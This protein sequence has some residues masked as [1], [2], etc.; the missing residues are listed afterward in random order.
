MKHLRT[1]LAAIS[2]AAFLLL[3]APPLLL[4]VAV[5]L[6]LADLMSA[7]RRRRKR[8]AARDVSKQAVSVVIPT[9]N[10]REHLARN[11]PSVVRAL[12]A[13][14]ENEI[15]VMENGS[16]DGTAELL[17]ESFPSVR[18]V[19][20]GSNLGFGR[21]SNYG[22]TL[23]RHDIV[24]LLNNDMRVESDFLGPLVDGFRDPRVFAVTA[25]IHFSDPAKSR[26]E[27]GLTMGRWVRGGIHLRHVAD[28]Q[29]DE[30]FPT[31]YAGGGSTAYDRLKVLELG[32]YDEL[33]APF[34][35]EDVDLSYMAWKR[36]WINLY[37]PASMVHH[38]HRGTIGTHFS[39]EFIDQ[40]LQKNRLLFVWKNMHH[41]GL[42]LA[43]FGWLYADMWASLIAGPSTNRCGVRGFLRALGQSFGA[44][45]RRSSARLLAEI[46]DSEAFRRPLGGFFRDRYHR[47]ENKPD[48]DLNVL[49][50]SPYPIEPPT[51]G[52]AVFMKQATEGLAE[53]CRLHLLC[54][55]ERP[56][57]VARH[58]GLTSRC[59][60]AELVV[61]DPGLYRGAPIL[62]P[63]SAQSYWDPALLWK[64]HRTILLRRIDIVQLE[65]AQL[66]SYGERF[67]QVVCCLF[68]HDLHFQSVQRAILADGLGGILHRGYEYMRSLRFEL[69]ALPRFDAIQV[70]STEQRRALN[71]LCAGGP[72]VLDN[73]RTAIELSTYPCKI[74]DREPDTMLFVGNFRH[75][76]NIKGLQHF[77]Q[78]ILPLIRQ[79][80]PQSR[81]IVVGADAPE[82]LQAILAEDG[83]EFLGAVAD[84][85]AVLT[86]YAV[87]V[88]P[89]LSGSG[90]R[91]KIL[92]AF[93]CGI[94]VVSTR[95]GAE[96]LCDGA[97]GIA[98]I[99]DRPQ[100]FAAAVVKLL[101]D[102]GQSVA[103]VREAR[104]MVRRNWDAASALP[105]LL[106]HYSA[107][108]ETKLLSR[109]AY[110]PPLR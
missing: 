5:L 101:S 79:G 15:L 16:E 91:V 110:P 24:V 10:G 2:V 62:W 65:Y 87:F 58:A 69:Q 41:W 23:A 82:N 42:L 25:Q 80:R 105:R 72:P 77:R 97:S 7:L 9:W 85:R 75:P 48:A 39:P 99:A 30:L 13:N 56:E 53:R 73:V 34:Y 37:A 36:G 76:P 49:F 70:C 4:A 35:M 28:D 21:A 94:P 95:L 64:I 44:A 108:L 8:P 66:A 3:L 93:A 17:A 86:R 14:P 52:G 57:D 92:E 109:V 96:G 81:L 61:H 45:A 59:A 63:H 104:Q 43:H 107:A 22:F 20:M 98:A 1:L 89:I 78:E 19:E 31:F 12:A 103:Q 32:G 6:A 26:E 29:V 18:V 88:A 54:L 27:T 90:I 67:R 71:A 84:I 83:I 74:G 68:E 40:I 47:L 100:A 102:P 60:S 11:L 38:E 55:I 33:L 50:V 51:H 46:P 106:A